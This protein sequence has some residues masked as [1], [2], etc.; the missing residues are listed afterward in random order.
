MNDINTTGTVMAPNALANGFRN[1]PYV[2]E[3]DVIEDTVHV[4]FSGLFDGSHAVADP[5]NGYV[6]WKLYRQGVPQATGKHP[7]TTD[8]SQTVA[9]AVG[10]ACMKALAN[11]SLTCRLLWSVLREENPELFDGSED[12]PL[13]AVGYEY[14]PFVEAACDTCGDDPE[15]LTIEYLTHGGEVLS[16]IYWDFGLPRL[17]E[18]A[19]KWNVP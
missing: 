2:K 6:G 17:L 1:L 9:R 4:H 3:A 16:E 10:C 18:T 15:M 19:E 5:R 14:S 13:C 7:L 11:L 8:D 12:M